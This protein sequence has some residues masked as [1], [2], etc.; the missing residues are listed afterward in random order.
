MRALYTL[1]L[2]R[3]QQYGRGLL[4][5]AFLVLLTVSSALFWAQQVSEK[6][7]G[8]F[9]IP[10]IF[11]IFIVGF[12]MFYLVPRAVLRTIRFDHPTWVH[13]FLGTV[14]GVVVCLFVYFGGIQSVIATTI[15]GCY[16]TY[17]LGLIVLRLLFART[18]HKSLSRTFTYGNGTVGGVKDKD[19]ELGDML[20]FNES[21]KNVL[22]ALL[23][24]GKPVSVIAITGTQG[25]GKSTYWRIIAEGLNKDKTLHTYISLTETNSEHDFAKLFAERWFETLGQRYAFLGT[26]DH[27]KQ[28]RLFNVLRESSNGFIKMIFGFTQPLLTVGLFKTGTK[29]YDPASEITN[30]D[31]V[32]DTV[33]RMFYHI[34]KLAEDR[35]FI[36][37]DEL[38]RAPFDEVYRVIEVIERFRQQAK[39]GFPLKVIFVLCVDKEKAE[40]N[41]EEHADIT[42]KTSLIKDFLNSNKHI[43][44]YFAV[45][46]TDNQTKLQFVEIKMLALI[47]DN[48][49]KSRFVPLLKDVYDFESHA[50]KDVNQ[51]FIPADGLNK[52]DDRYSQIMYL[53]LSETPRTIVRIIDQTRALLM[54]HRDETGWLENYSLSE[55][56]IFSYLSVVEPT[57]VKIAEEVFR[58]ID[59]E[60]PASDRLL[61]IWQSRKEEVAPKQRLYDQYAFDYR[62]LDDKKF[63]EK[64]EPLRIF[65]PRVYAI[66]LNAKDPEANDLIAY[67]GTLSERSLFIS[68]VSFRRFIDEDTTFMRYLQEIE[69]GHW[70]AALEGNATLLYNFSGFIRNRTT[71]Q[72]RTSAISFNIAEHI[73]KYIKNTQ[74][75]LFTPSDINSDRNMLDKLTYEFVFQLEDAFGRTGEVNELSEQCMSLFEDFI[76]SKR[77]T[78]EA[79]LIILNAFLDKDGSGYD[80]ARI[81]RDVMESF[82]GRDYFPRLFKEIQED[83]FAKYSGR[84]NATLYRGEANIFYVLH[85]NW[86]GDL[87]DPNIHRLK[88]MARKGIKNTAALRAWWNVYPYEEEWKTYEQ[89][90]KDGSQHILFHPARRGM[91]ISLVE[92][93]R[94][95]KGSKEFQQIVDDDPFLKSKISFWQHIMAEDK[96]GRYLDL[97][98]QNSPAGRD[99]GTVAMRMTQLA[100]K[101]TDKSKPD[102]Q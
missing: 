102:T 96:D 100:K 5:F 94:Y 15:I 44:G 81:R 87:N 64:M 9:F 62:A 78:F 66:A 59:P 79:K 41:L 16:S 89:F 72:R 69:A 98:A 24:F 12:F 11:G 38:E 75:R 28:L 43:D 22:K 14:G 95:T 17:L 88:D 39:N 55:Y 36:V 26:A 99:D 21:A 58:Q 27:S 4:V 68:L 83:M 46:Y 77:P 91:F 42:E 20:G 86:N 67:R 2:R 6:G 57:L 71:W 40:S 31:F 93:I 90:K 34:P 30:P 48:A 61:A 33:A 8:E 25:S 54:A 97:E 63:T 65:M 19:R 73:W 85:Q 82:K 92:L 35:W 84:G 76:Y 74:E 45:P 18:R 10:G 80:R 29:A 23:S 13:L 53:L 60:A 101:Q 7:T 50:L 52:I 56:L 51:P 49:K 1:A 70:P 47:P 3:V 37:I 32:D